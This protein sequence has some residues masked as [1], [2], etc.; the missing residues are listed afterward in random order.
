MC[1]L[2]LLKKNGIH[3]AGIE[4]SQKGTPKERTTIFGRITRT[5]STAET[6]GFFT[7]SE[8]SPKGEGGREKST[9]PAQAVT[10]VW[11]LRNES[12]S[13]KLM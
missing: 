13:T 10:W 4:P 3:R 11:T 2:S 12:K 1:N 6:Q 5:I 9:Y 8:L 7:G